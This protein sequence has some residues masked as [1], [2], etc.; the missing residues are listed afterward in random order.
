MGCHFLFQVE[1][2]M[3]THSRI[4]VWEIP[5]MEEL[6]QLQSMGLHPGVKPTHTSCVPCI[7]RQTLYQLHHLESPSM[8]D[9]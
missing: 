8:Y 2:E 6:G 7:G 1:K 3:A 9:L 4:L 5:L